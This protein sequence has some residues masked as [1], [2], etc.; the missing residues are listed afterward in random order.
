MKKICFLTALL[1]I[2]VLVPTGCSLGK[3]EVKEVGTLKFVANGEDFAREGFISK[4][5]WR[6]SFDHVYVNLADITGY[7]ANPPYDAYGGGEIKSSSK[8]S[9]DK[10]YTMDIAQGEG[11]SVVGKVENAPVGHYNAIS[12]SMVKGNGGPAE[13]NVLVL[14]GDAKKENKTINFSIKFDQELLIK[15]GEFIGDERKGIV[16]RGKEAELEMTFHLDHIFGDIETPA[17][18]DLNLG[19]LGFEPF[20]NIAENGQLDVDNQGLKTKLSN[21]DYEK[22]SDLLYSLPHVGEGHC[23][24]EKIRG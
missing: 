7:Q 12:W 19:S 17:D 20:A 6:I 11:P 15:A 9:L 21:S 1:L 23:Y 24:V 2:F 5:N 22:L 13:G 8:V 3:K 4:D 18:D 10:I 16:Q 14:I